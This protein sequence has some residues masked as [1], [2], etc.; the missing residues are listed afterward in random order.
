MLSVVSFI[1]YSLWPEKCFPGGCDL[2]A[3]SSLSTGGGTDTLFS[4]EEFLVPSILFDSSL[5]VTM[6]LMV[7]YP[8]CF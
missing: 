1:L 7:L 5:R 2:L 6:L 8:I 3:C 4:A